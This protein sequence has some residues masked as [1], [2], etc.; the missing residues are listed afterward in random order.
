[1]HHKCNNK[2]FILI[3]MLLFRGI[4]FAQIPVE[5]FIGHKKSTFD[6]MFFKMIDFFLTIVSTMKKQLFHEKISNYRFEFLLIA[7]LLLIFDKILFLDNNIYLKFVWPFNMLL[8]SVASFGIFTE[9]NKSVKWVRNILGL[10][11]ISMPF[12]FMFLSQNN[13]FIEF[14]TLF[15]IIYYC[16]IFAEVMYQ[17]TLTKEIRINVIIGSFCGY[18]LLSMIALF[19]YLFIEYNFSNS[20]KGIST[21]NIPLV[22]NE[23]SYFSFITLTSIGFGDIHPINDTSRLVTAFFGMVGQFYM[24]AIVGIIISKFASN[25]N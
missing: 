15:F 16:F 3:E 2:T 18:M 10:I 17:I 12:G 19:T 22:Y 11:S 13:W 1:M 6:V 5:V 25:N 4:A 14:L 9:R 20:F 24:V 21:G 23:L 7:L 8:I